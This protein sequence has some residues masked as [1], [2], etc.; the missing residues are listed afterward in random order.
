MKT[1]T[2]ITAIAALLF[3]AVTT[4]VAQENRFAGW[5][6]SNANGWGYKI[7]AGY[8]LGGTS[9]IPLP[10][11]VRSIN[12]YHPEGGLTFGADAY[13]MFNKRWGM[14][15]GARFFM[16]GMYT[17]ADVK[18]YNMGITQGEDYLEGR[19]TGTDI[20][21][22][23]MVGVTVPLLVTL[24]CN[25]RW[26]INV[27]PYVSFL[28]YRDFEGSV[29]NGYLREGD[30]TGQKIEITAE[31]PATYDFSSDMRRVLY[32]LEIGADFKATPKM[33][34]FAYLDWGLN[35][36]FKSSFKTVSF[37]MYPLYATVGLA[38]VY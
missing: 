2:Y 15:M 12:S 1:K 14:S 4:V 35:G 23:F 27:G 11:E 17:G 8:T 21:E 19:F 26:N 37:N 20:T 34:A 36:V 16:E 38:Y 25:H 30:P 29:F 33:T 28:I 24:R 13:K 32:G 3:L 22:T 5:G 7:R 18:N 9:P 31:N 10:E 6:P